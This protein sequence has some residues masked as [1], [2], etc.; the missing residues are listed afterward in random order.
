MV[1]TDPP[2][3]TEFRRLVSLARWALR[4]IVSF[5]AVPG[6]DDE[7]ERWLVSRF[8]APVLNVR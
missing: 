1:M 3:H 2:V 6:S 4:C 7:E 5:L 8:L